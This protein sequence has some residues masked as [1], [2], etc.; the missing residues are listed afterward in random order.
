MLYMYFVGLLVIG[1]VWFAVSQH[2]A[3]YN[4]DWS[5]SWSSLDKAARVDANCSPIVK[6][7]RKMGSTDVW[8]WT[9]PK[10]CEQGLPHTR[11]IDVIAI[12]DG[13]PHSRLPS[14]LDHEKI[15]LL[16]RQMPESWA[17]FYRIAWNYE[18]YTAP[19]VGMPTELVE[20]LR[21][22]PDTADTPWC[23]WRGRWW[24][25]PVYQSRKN[26]S[27]RDAPVKWWDAE[28]GL[29]SITPPEDWLRFFGSGVHQL[30]HP[31]EMTAEYLAGPLR[32]GKLPSGAPD[33]MIRLRDAWTDDSLFPSTD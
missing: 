28:T 3:F 25:V 31:H 7:R 21:A 19:P 4:Y 6:I 20:M 14:T 10:T 24:S 15:H 5:H 17:R 12:P 32:G 26:L 18:L 27:L 29:I 22:N 11:S 1:I 33:G 9:V 13:F 23:C 30:E 2:D 8:I 16:Q